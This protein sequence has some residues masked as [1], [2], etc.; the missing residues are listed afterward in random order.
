MVW[1]VH[2]KPTAKAALIELGLRTR[3]VIELVY[4]VVGKSETPK[5][6]NYER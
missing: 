6:G 3:S 1:E 5:E 2:A 4:L